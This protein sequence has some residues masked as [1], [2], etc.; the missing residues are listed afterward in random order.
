VLLVERQS[1]ADAARTLGVA[2]LSSDTLILK[3]AASG[4]S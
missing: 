4:H 2:D 1:V 3:A